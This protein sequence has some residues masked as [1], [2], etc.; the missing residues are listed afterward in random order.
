[1][2]SIYTETCLYKHLIISILKK[3]NILTRFDIVNDLTLP[4]SI[5]IGKTFS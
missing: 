3:Y 2:V 4:Q 1:M 5:K